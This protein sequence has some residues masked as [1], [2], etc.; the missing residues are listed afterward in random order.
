MATKT[1]ME[2][3]ELGKLLAEGSGDVLR[4]LLAR[5][6]RMVMDSE[7]AALCGAEHGE[8]SDERVNQRNGYRERDLETRLGTVSLAI[9]KLRQGSYLPSFLEP[10]RLW[11]QAFVAAVAEAYIAGVST[12]RVEQL[13]E[14]MGAKGMSRST[15]SRMVTE[16][17]AT[18]KDF[19]E[20]ILSLEYP[21]LW[22]DA[23]YVKVREGGRVVSR[24]VLIAYAVSV[25]GQREV[26]GVEV[27]AGEMTQCWRQFLGQLLARGLQ[28]VKLVISDAHEGLKGAIQAC[29]VGVT[30]QRCTVHFARNVC[31][32]LPKSHQGV[33][34][35]A[36]STVFKQPDLAA[37]KIAM[38][39][40]LE[41]LKK[42][43]RAAAVAEAGEVDVLSFYAFP[44]AHWRQLHSTNPLERENR[45]IRRRTDVV[46]IFP[47]DASVKRLVVS[48][49]IDQNAAWAVGKRYL[50]LE[51]M[52]RLKGPDG[53]GSPPAALAEVAAG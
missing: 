3:A 12:R 33:V 17:D 53:N 4:A 14:A 50:S 37:A 51:S 27:A 36:L 40:V 25:E 49:L 13:V 39:K 47:N 11:E 29:L 22:L 38:G 9:P 42:H 34:G 5:M 31:A 32:L 15:V 44:Q 41:L 28:G 24:A 2:T 23:L 19:N 6:L 45:E 10:R 43:P 20:R 16:V 7:V 52:A 1:V 8:R 26:L 21:Y 18:V 35:A 48:L 46:G 30:W